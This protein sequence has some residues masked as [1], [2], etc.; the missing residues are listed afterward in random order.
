[1]VARSGDV[2]VDRPVAQS[3]HKLLR[4]LGLAALLAAPTCA[5][6]TTYTVTNTNDSGAGSL[7]AAI[8]SAN[9]STSSPHTIN[10]NIAGTGVKTINLTSA[11]PS[12]NRQTT[13]DGTTQPGYA[14]T[15][16]IELNGASAGST[17]YGLVIYGNNSAVKGLSINRFGVDGIWLQANNVTVTGNYLG[18][19]PDGVTDRGNAF[20]GI[21]VVGSNNTIGG[22]TSALRNVM[23][24]NG[25][26]GLHLEGSGNVVLGNYF[27]TNAAGSAAIANDV[28]GICIYDSSGHTI[29]GTAAG[30]GNVLSGNAYDGLYISNASN[31]TIQGNIFGLDASGTNAIGNGYNGIA[32]EDSS[33]ITIGGSAGGARNV[34][35]GNTGTW[36]DGMWISSSSAVTIKGN[37]I[38]LDAAGTAARPNKGSGVNLDNSSDCA[39]GGTASGEGNVIAGNQGSGISIGGSGASGNVVLG[40]FIGTNAPGTSTIG[41]GGVGVYLSNSAVGSTIGTTA[42]GGGNTIAGSGGAAVATSGSATRFH[43]IR[44]NSLWSN[45]G[46]GIDLGNDGVTP[47]TGAKSSASP[48][49]HMHFPVITSATLTGTSLSVA[50]YVG[51]A[52]GQAPFADSIVDVYIDAGN[53]T[54]QGK[55]YLGTL[56]TGS[57]ACTSNCFSGTL[58]V[59]ATMTTSDKIVATATDTLN[60]TSEFGAAATVAAGTVSPGAFN[61]FE[62]STASAAVTG[63]IKTKVAGATSTLALVA[64]DNTRT[65]YVAADLT[66]ITIEILDAGD[67]SGTLDA[68][69]QC[70]S[71]WTVAGTLGAGFSMAA[72][73][74]GRKNVSFTLTASRRN[75]RFRITSG[76][77]VGCTTDNFAVRPA[78]FTGLTAT[79]GTDTTTGTTRTL[80]NGSETA[81]VV[82]R[83]GRNFS[84]VARAVNSNGTTTASAYTGTAVLAVAACIAPSGCMAGT[85][86]SSL[87]TTAGNVA[88]T[89]SY[90]E[91]GV[92]GV[93]LADTTWAAVDAADSTEVER[94]ISTAAAVTVGRFV[95]DA[96]RLTVATTPAFAPPAC[97]A[98][99]QSFVYV[100]QSFSFGTTPQ[101]LAT[102]V[103]ASGAVLANARPRFTVNEVAST[104][105]ASNANAAFAGSAAASGLSGTSA[106]TVAFATGAMSFTRATTPVA[107]F[108]PSIT[109]TVNVA[110]TTE[111]ATAGNNTINGEAALAIGPIAFSNGATTFHY[112]RISLRP[113]FGD[114]RRDLVVPLEVQSYNG[115][116]WVP[117]AAAANCLSAAATAFAYSEPT[118]ALA[119]SGAF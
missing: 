95:A 62:T 72:A 57:G 31:L 110:D 61:M 4:C 9:G 96:Y 24:G 88:G 68:T 115:L 19:T 90:S 63:P 56:T 80:A 92:I 70:R 76:S 83:A 38:G 66:S 14:G 118:G 8:T 101:V 12:V 71:S 98:G 103:N 87:M 112:G 106:I 73:D 44:G 48:N 16:L 89:A 46:I 107:A 79:D 93:H 60:N 85:L 55:T 119:D 7:R 47:N 34:V 3:L 81:G 43:A 102:P 99:A 32:I 105:A 29:G 69:T 75:T 104:L 41:N 52:A 26:C 86:T 10:F 40:N 77:T 94:T 17:T 65:A 33:N 58:T 109:H 78:S 22:T 84:V 37:Y 100:G 20:D 113:T 114:W 108:T 28:D 13:I 74:G 6:A 116:G 97:G 21:T 42:S 23:S 36:S 53:T 35:S 2:S 25:E 67:D 117:L 54:R 91:A 27:G 51:S 111:T 30:S 39:I 82:H 49:Y 45:S 5:L 50:G 1:M 18:V 15:P 59:P 11:L 64:L